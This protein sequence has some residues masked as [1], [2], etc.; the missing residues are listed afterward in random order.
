MF[1]LPY[2]EINDWDDL[3]IELPDGSVVGG[4][5]S[6]MYID[7][8]TIPDGLHA[9]DIRHAN[10]DTAR[11]MCLVKDCVSVNHFGTFVTPKVIEGSREGRPIMKYSLGCTEEDYRI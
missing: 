9:Y 7:R 5:F 8:D 11:F 10:Y 2:D 6:N 3:V 1:A 4:R